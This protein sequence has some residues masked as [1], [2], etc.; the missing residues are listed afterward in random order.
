MSTLTPH[1]K[2]ADAGESIRVLADLPV[3]ATIQRLLAG[4]VELLPWDAAL[5]AEARSIAAIYTY[6]H[7][8]VDASLLDRLPAVRVISNFGV[9]VDHIDLTAAAARGIPGVLFQ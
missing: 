7:P 2:P 5:G 8:R 4:R 1:G 9:G 6:G 3:S